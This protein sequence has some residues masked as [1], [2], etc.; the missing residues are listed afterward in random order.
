[1]FTLAALV[2]TLVSGI[3][4]SQFEPATAQVEKIETQTSQQKAD[5]I[6]AEANLEMGYT[7]LYNDVHKN[8]RFLIDAL[9]VDIVPPNILFPKGKPIE[10][11]IIS[12][13][14]ES[15]VKMLSLVDALLSFQPNASMLEL[16]LMLDHDPNV[17]WSKKSSTVS[18]EAERTSRRLLGPLRLAISGIR[19]VK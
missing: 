10:S 11:G 4:G 7:A 8:R 1:M 2:M 15:S 17:P 16:R 3:F 9:K 5:I 18:E 19:P 13:Q 12:Q 14:L 6:L